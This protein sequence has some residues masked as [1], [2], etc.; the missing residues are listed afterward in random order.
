MCVG[1]REG[2]VFL[3]AK[4]R[5][6]SAMA[7][8]AP[9]ASKLFSSRSVSV[10]RRIS[11]GWSL[12]V[13]KLVYNVHVWPVLIGPSRRLLNNVY[14]RLWRRIANRP[15]FKAGGFSDVEVRRSLGVV[16]LDCLIRKRRLKYLGRLLRASIP[17]L[18]AMLSVRGQAGRPTWVDTI[19][20]DLCVLRRRLG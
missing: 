10:R 11:L 5:S 17:A 6:A 14:M 4:S 15:R 13:S 8:C 7:S 3:D 9:L 2:S 20:N 16:S 18:S 19:T 12:I 1:I